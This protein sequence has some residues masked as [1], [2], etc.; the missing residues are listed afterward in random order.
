VY[1]TLKLFF[2]PHTIE[3]RN[4]VSN[5]CFRTRNFHFFQ[6]LEKREFFFVN[7][8][9]NF[10]EEKLEALSNDGKQEGA[11]K[12]GVVV[13]DGG[14]FVFGLGEKKVFVTTESHDDG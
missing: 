5:G 8:I 1:L 14:V 13:E 3:G 2:R 7:Y 12:G 10:V 6:G 11:G 4:P 9:L